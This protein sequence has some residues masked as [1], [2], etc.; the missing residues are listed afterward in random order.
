MTVAGEQPSLD[1]VEHGIL[2]GSRSKY[3]FWRD[4]SSR[5]QNYVAGFSASMATET[6]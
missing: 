6:T 3:G 5:E 4:V 2:R 1:D